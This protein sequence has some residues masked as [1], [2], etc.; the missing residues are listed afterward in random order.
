MELPQDGDGLG[1]VFAG[2]GGLNG[3]AMQGLWRLLVLFLP[4]GVLPRRRPPS[5]RRPAV[6]L[7]RRRRS[8]TLPR[9]RRA[10]PLRMRR[11]PTPLRPRRRRPEEV[12]LL[13]PEVP[14]R[15]PPPPP[16]FVEGWSE[17]LPGRGRRHPLLLLTPCPGIEFVHRRGTRVHR[18]SRRR[19]HSLFHLGE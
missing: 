17:V 10:P 14:V 1:A 4:E 12:P 7:S 11:R 9:R 16:A 19:G 15:T 2:P 18:L 3:L 5:R 13:H 6:S 8:V